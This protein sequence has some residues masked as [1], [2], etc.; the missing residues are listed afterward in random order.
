M[1]NALFLSCPSGDS[2]RRGGRLVRR[3]PGDAAGVQDEEEG[4]GQLHAG[5]TQ[6]GHRHL[7]ETRQAGGVLCITP[8]RQRDTPHTRREKERGR[9][10]RKIL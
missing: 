4:R 8:I 2:G 3:L 5:G 1:T 7:P 6:T 10:E 9:E